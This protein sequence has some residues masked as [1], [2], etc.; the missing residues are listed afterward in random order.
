MKKTALVSVHDDP[1]YG[2]ALQ[3]YALAFAIKREGYDCEYINYTPVIP[4]H[5]T[6]TKMRAMAKK[7][8]YGYGILKQPKSEYSFWRTPEFQHQ[9]QLFTD[10]HDAK[11]PFSKTKYNP[12]TIQETNNIYDCF[13][14][15]SDQTWSPYTTKPKYTINFL[16]FVAEGKTKGSYAPSFGTCHIEEEYIEKL[17]EKIANFDYLSCRERKNA[18]LLTKRIGKH[19]EYVLDPTLLLNKEE[20]LS[21]AEPVVMPERY[22]LC[23][24]LGTKQ[25]I[26]DFAEKMGS[27][28]SIPVYYIVSRPEYLHKQNA[29]K[30]VSPGQFI[31]LISR[32]ESVVTDS[33]HGSLFSINFQRQFYAFTKRDSASGPID[34]DRI[35]DFLDVMGLS[36]RLKDDD[37]QRFT[38]PIDYVLVDNGLKELLSSSRV[39]LMKLLKQ[40][41]EEFN[42][43]ML[44]N[45]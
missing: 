14:I 23:Y 13:I 24:I 29:L 28:L 15:G 22:I 26:A 32:A 33:F 2:S 36:E 19:V 12:L 31:S 17:T 5:D 4:P 37:D 7:V 42:K 1:N 40:K 41:E 43:T 16:D 6:R 34:N 11:I 9:R 44:N 25:C 38:S 18:E 21:I 35:G 10:F 20:W 27:E 30:N 8:L 39:Y 45:Y 3:A